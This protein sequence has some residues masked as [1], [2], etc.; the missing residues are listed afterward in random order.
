MAEEPT[1]VVFV[2]GLKG[3]PA[4]KMVAGAHRAVARD[5]LEG[6]R[7]TGVFPRAILVTDSPKLF[8]WDDGWLTVEDTGGGPFHFGQKLKE[9]IHKYGIQ[10]LLYLGGGSV[11]LLP[12]AQLAALGQQL[13]STTNAVITNNLF[14]ADLLAFTPAQIIDHVPLPD[15][16]NPLAR[17]FKDAGLTPIALPYEATTQ[18][19]VDTPI[20][21]M[22]LKLHPAI[23]GHTKTYLEHL[24]LDLSRLRYAITFFTQ[25][26]AQILV[27]GRVGSRTWAHLETETACRVR[28]LSEER[29]MDAEGRSQQGQVRSILGFYL[30]EVGMAR[31]FAT[32]G[33]LGDAAFIDSRVILHHLQLNPSLSDRFYSDLG[34]PEKIKNPILRD[35]TQEALNA[36]IPVILGGHSLVAGGLMALIETAW[37]K[38]DERKANSEKS[39]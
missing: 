13:A 3:S 1:L 21:L 34:Q 9:V 10:S 2:G 16:D 36:P 23:R 5:I 33:E 14:S 4:V 7:E 39:D 37:L 15:R 30:K 31:F 29:G 25:P 17:S 32:L 27:A 19:D 8:T 12:S 22:I 6:A 18:F 24:D 35:F 11:P 20:D 28:V 26:T 38:E